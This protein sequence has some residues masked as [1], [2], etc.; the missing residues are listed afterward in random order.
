M[1]RGLPEQKKCIESRTE[2][3]RDGLKT[4]PIFFNPQSAKTLER[5][6]PHDRSQNNCGSPPFRPIRGEQAKAVQF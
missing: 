2:R 1:S 3:Q 6:Y 4:F 5:P